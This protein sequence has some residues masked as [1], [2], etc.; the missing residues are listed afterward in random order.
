MQEFGWEEEA[1]VGDS[2]WGRWQQETGVLS[3][4]MTRVQILDFEDPGFWLFP[5]GFA[6]LLFPA[7]ST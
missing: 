4:T 7:H 3:Y 1:E 2:D 6:S 5:V